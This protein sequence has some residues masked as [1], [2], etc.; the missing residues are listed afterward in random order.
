MDLIT[1]SSF[2]KPTGISSNVVITG[3]T[4]LAIFTALDNMLRDALRAKSSK[5]R[6]TVPP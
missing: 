6:Q 5:T 4:R 1:L 3:K 2:A